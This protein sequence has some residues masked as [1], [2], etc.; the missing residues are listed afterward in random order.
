MSRVIKQIAILMVTSMCLVGC[1]DNKSV[2]KEEV[3]DEVVESVEETDEIPKDF[4]AVEITE[5]M[6]DM[7][8]A[9][10][11]MLFEKEEKY[12]AKV[13]GY[14]NKE[15]YEEVKVKKDEGA[16]VI[17][18][19]SNKGVN[20][21]TLDATIGANVQKNELKDVILRVNGKVVAIY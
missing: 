1:R 13:V 2:I 17:D 5:D 9:L 20:T 21:Q 4:S 3:V 10:D 16:Y 8:K 12:Y 15:K 6:E 14:D 11:G 19:T 18:I 7:Y